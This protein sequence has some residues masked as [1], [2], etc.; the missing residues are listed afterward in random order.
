MRPGKPLMAGRLKG[1]AMVGLPGNPV[2]SLVCG[3]VF[4]V[5]M[6]RAMLGLGAA[7][8]PRM[9]A[10]LTENI[11]ENGARE[12]YMRA[13]VDAQGIRLLPR[14]DSSLLTILQQS[15][16]LLLRPVGDPPRH[17]GDIVDYLPL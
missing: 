7:P 15:N 12:H 11:P 6:L 5:P 2:S 16:A 13:V 3:Q 17:A 10:V 8:A 1:A 4:L 9:Q 14:Q